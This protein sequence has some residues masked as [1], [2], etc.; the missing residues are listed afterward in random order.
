MEALIDLVFN[1]GSSHV[2]F[3]HLI[4]EI[5]VS[6]TSQ[7]LSAK[8]NPP[9]SDRPSLMLNFSRA[10]IP[11]PA[12]GGDSGYSA[13]LYDMG[14]QFE[15]E[16]MHRKL[17]GKG[18]CGTKAKKPGQVHSAALQWCFKSEHLGE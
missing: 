18:W 7:T 16:K 11:K 2:G 6:R 10:Q 15:D 5:P 14:L 1:F 8:T 3:V 4:A 12:P 9:V 17:L 13:D